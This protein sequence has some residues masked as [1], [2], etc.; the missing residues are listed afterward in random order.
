MHLEPQRRKVKGEPPLRGT[1][2]RSLTDVPLRRQLDQP[3]PLHHLGLVLKVSEVVG[4]ASHQ[5]KA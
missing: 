1:A 3:S 5:L 4:D 2:S